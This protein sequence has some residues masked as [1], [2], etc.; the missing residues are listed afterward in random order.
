MS[1]STLP[2]FPTFRN[3]THEGNGVYRCQY[4]GETNVIIPGK[5]GGLPTL[6]HCEKCKEEREFVLDTLN[7]AEQE[8]LR[9][10]EMLAQEIRRE[11]SNSALIKHNANVVARINNVE[12]A[13]RNHDKLIRAMKEI[14]AQDDLRQLFRNHFI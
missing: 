8:Y 4:H 10:R 3:R 13:I 7:E 5:H 11:M 14:K 12:S 2:T 1:T 6:P 9:L